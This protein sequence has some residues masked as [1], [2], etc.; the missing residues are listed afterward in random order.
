MP[1]SE[2]MSMPYWS[3]FRLAMFHDLAI[4][5]RSWPLYLGILGL[6]ILLAFIPKKK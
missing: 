6:G 4:I 5:L 3:L 2:L 1:F